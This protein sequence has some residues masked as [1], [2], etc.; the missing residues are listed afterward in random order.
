MSRDPLCSCAQ[1]AC[2]ALDLRLAADGV[3]HPVPARHAEKMTPRAL[4]N[5]AGRQLVADGALELFLA[6][7]GGSGATQEMR[8]PP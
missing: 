2:A 5:L 4:V 3:V 1:V 7:H 8:R 6:H